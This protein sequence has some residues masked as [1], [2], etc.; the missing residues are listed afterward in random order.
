MKLYYSPNSPFA[1]IARIS[2]RESGLL[3]SASEELAA[4]RHPDN[5]VLDYSPV[6]R[7]PTLI[8]GELVIT[9]AKCVFGYLA[10]KSGSATMLSAAE[11]DWKELGQEGQILGFVDGIA[12]WVR[13]NRRLPAVQ[14]SFLIDVERERL[15]RCLHYL[16]KE[17]CAHRLPEFPAFR[18]I[19][20][21]AGLGLMDW[22]NFHPGWRSEHQRLSTWFETLE[23]RTSMQETKPA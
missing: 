12:N 7:V 11:L 21:A 8:D 5:P 17:A 23:I 16:E 4:S 18:G 19:A 22:H 1:R 2:L 14:S 20:L 9:E 13:E 3:S 10:A 15:K 6:G